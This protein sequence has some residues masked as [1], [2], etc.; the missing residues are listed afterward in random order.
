MKTESQNKSVSTSSWIILI[1]IVLIFIAPTLII[2]ISSFKMDRDVFS[3]APK[4]LFTPSIINFQYL[5]KWPIFKGLKNSLIVSFFT[6]LLVVLVSLPAA[7]S[8]SRLATKKLSITSIFLILVRMFPPIV[9]T[10]P[11]YPVLN[12]IGLLDTKFVL[13]FIY[14]VLHV[15]LITMLLKTFVDGIPYELEEQAQIDGATMSYSF[16]KIIL[17]LMAP[18]V[19]T[20]VILVFLH[21]W[22]EF[23]FAFL[24]TGIKS[25]TLPVVIAEMLGVVGQGG[26]ISWG[27]IFAAS[28]IQLIPILLVIWFSQRW[29]I[30]GMK[31]GGVKE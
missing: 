3:Y 14:A 25:K 17:P 5:T 4:L 24:M 29:L 10:I 6:C 11:L 21:T 23:D 27:I 7:Y 1:F 19:V 15:S 20:S 31:I 28:C 22:N 8:Y 2:I 16:I 12:R 13:I 18:G 30:S 9:I 26:Y